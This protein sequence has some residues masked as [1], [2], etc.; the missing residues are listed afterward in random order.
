MR[1]IDK[2]DDEAYDLV[3]VIVQ[4]VQIE[5]V[6]PILAEFKNAKAFLFIGN[7]VNGFENINAHLDPD[8]ILAGF[9]TVG[10]KKR[11]T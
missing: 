7:N 6:L 4:M 5:K 10:G 2:P 3:M 8:K 1:V 9:I 11:G